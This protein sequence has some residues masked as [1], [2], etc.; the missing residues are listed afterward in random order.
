MGCARLLERAAGIEEMAVSEAVGALCR[1]LLRSLEDGAPPNVALMH[2]FLRAHDIRDAGLAID[3]ALGASQ[4]GGRTRARVH[5]VA[6]LW[7]R[8][9]DAWN[10][11]RTGA[12]EHGA[13]HADADCAVHRW[14]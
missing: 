8:H 4:R 14:A 5:E 11:V 9:P 10:V 6:A 3:A 2:L 1:E 12:A 13:T 7:R